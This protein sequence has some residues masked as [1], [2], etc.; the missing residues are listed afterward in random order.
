M[1]TYGVCNN[2][3]GINQYTRYGAGALRRKTGALYHGSNQ[4]GLKVLLPKVNKFVILPVAHT[5]VSGLLYCDWDSEAALTAVELEVLK[6]LR[7]LFLPFCP[8]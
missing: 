5:S 4:A 3:A 6:K 1:G 2:P 8:A 7:G